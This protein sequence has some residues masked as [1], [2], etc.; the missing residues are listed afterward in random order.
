MSRL[1]A[2]FGTNEK[3]IQEGAW[4]ELLE[5]EDGSTCR[6]RIKRM[7]QQNTNFAKQIAN[8]RNA[9]QTNHVSEKKLSQMQASMIEVLID[10]VIV[11]W[12]NFENWL[13]SPEE[14]STEGFPGS[15][16]PK[17]LPFTKDNVRKTLQEMPDL[18]DFITEQATEIT[19]FQKGED[20]KN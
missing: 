2:K 3:A 5:N 17:Y 4:I 10:T 15:E 20:E 13:D 8:H 11:D 18:V 9:F 19:N 1:L 6:I 7:N 14:K 16:K 12:D